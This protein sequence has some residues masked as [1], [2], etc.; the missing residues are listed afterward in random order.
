MTIGITSLPMWTVLMGSL[1]SCT[2]GDYESTTR[3]KTV[4]WVSIGTGHSITAEDVA[5]AV[6]GC[7]RT[8]RVCTIHEVST[9]APPEIQNQTGHATYEMEPCCPKWECCDSTSMPMD[10]V[11][12]T[13]APE[14]GC[15]G[16]NSKGNTPPPQSNTCDMSDKHNWMY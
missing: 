14:Y 11:N 13:A 10:G 12:V 3:N 7:D 5:S 4:Q 6:I 15:G 2:G 9:R 1:V 8:W 16:C